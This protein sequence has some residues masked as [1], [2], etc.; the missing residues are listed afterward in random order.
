MA[1]SVKG[2]QFPQE[3]MRMGVRWSVA[4]PLSPRHGEARMEERGVE[5]EH[6]TSTRGGIA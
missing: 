1:L 6:S 5:V 3:V 4:Y 2:A